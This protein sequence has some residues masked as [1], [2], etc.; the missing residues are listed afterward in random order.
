M[1][2]RWS[3][4]AACE[5]RCLG[6]SPDLSA[7]LA[8]RRRFDARHAVEEANDR[9]YQAFRVGPGG[10]GWVGA[11]HSSAVRFRQPTVGPRSG[12]WAVQTCA[13][14][15]ELGAHACLKLLTDSTSY[16]GPA[17]TAQTCH[18]RGSLSRRSLQEAPVRFARGLLQHNRLLAVA[19]LSHTK[20]LVGHWGHPP[21]LFPPTS[22][23]LLPHHPSILGTLH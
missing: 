15:R 5:C 12:G 21:S 3:A 6:S 23:R 11:E 9:F 22:L 13:V 18:P 1:P 20:P 4:R 2:C 16:G 7:C 8:R 14:R 19:N 17:P 10:S